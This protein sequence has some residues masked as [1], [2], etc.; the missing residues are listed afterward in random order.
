MAPRRSGR[1]GAALKPAS[2]AADEKKKEEIRGMLDF[3]AEKKA[4]ARI[5]SEAE[6]RN[7]LG[8]GDYLDAVTTYKT[9]ASP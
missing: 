5:E 6:W 7:G 8:E 4:Y 2:N 1:N 3:E 9:P